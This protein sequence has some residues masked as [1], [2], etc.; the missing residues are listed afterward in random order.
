MAQAKAQS[1]RYWCN[2]D[3]LSGTRLGRESSQVRIGPKT[4]LRLCGLPV[5]PEPR[6]SPTHSAEMADLER[7]DTLSPRK[8]ISLSKP[9]HVPH[10]SPDGN[11]K[12]DAV[13][14]ITHETHPVA[15]QTELAHPR[16]SREKHS[17]SRHPSPSTEVV[18]T[19]GQCPPR[20][21]PTPFATRSSTVYRRLKRRLG[22][23]LRRSYHKRFMV[24]AQKQTT[25]K[26]VRAQGHVV[27]PKRIP[28]PMPGT[29]CPDSH[30]QH[31]CGLLYKQGGRHEV[32][33]PLLCYYGGSCRGATTGT[34]LF[35][36][37]I[38]RVA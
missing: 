21:A 33:I 22:R 37:D 20:A 27:G 24:S 30:R 18:A 1:S 17:D 5:R 4:G 26:H 15:S 28:E 25:H 38:F 3:P 10:R 7:Q 9:V 8:V 16:I 31:H 11:R 32:R 23:S 6:S 19:G 29:G 12:T 35:R 34:S 2:P 13:R 14:K 36:R